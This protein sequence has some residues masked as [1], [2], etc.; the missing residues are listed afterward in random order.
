MTDITPASIGA[1][2]RSVTAKDR[3][4]GAPDVTDMPLDTT[5]L[6][7]SILDAAPGADIR[8]LRAAMD[9][10]VVT[11]QATAR[12]M[13]KGREDKHGKV[14][15]APMTPENVAAWAKTSTIETLSRGTGREGS[16]VQ[17]M[18]PDER[19]ERAAL[20]AQLAKLEKTAK[21]RTPKRAT[22]KP[23]GSKSAA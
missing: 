19:A 10:Y 22:A 8:V 21:E 9:S 4:D 6:G 12:G 16:V 20:K 3:I 18:T 5:A 14:T 7:Q 2:G 1:Q 13:L 17:A 11:L 15:H 23:K